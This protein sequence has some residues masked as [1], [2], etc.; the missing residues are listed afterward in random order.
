[1]S[2]AAQLTFS[3]FPTFKFRKCFDATGALQLHSCNSCHRAVSASFNFTNIICLATRQHSFRNGAKI[4]L[5]PFLRSAGCYMW[6][7]GDCKS[8]PPLWNVRHRCADPHTDV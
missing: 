2:V 3:T 8:G 6:P 4:V 5:N 7:G 1:M